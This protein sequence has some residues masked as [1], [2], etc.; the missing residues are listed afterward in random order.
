M[1]KKNKT[2]PIPDQTSATASTHP[3]DKSSDFCIHPSAELHAVVDVMNVSNFAGVQW[4]HIL[5]HPFKDVVYHGLAIVPYKEI[6]SLAFENVK[7]QAWFLQGLQK[8]LRNSL[9]SFLPNSK[10]ANGFSAQFC[11]ALELCCTD[12]QMQNYGNEGNV[13]KDRATQK[14]W[15][16]EPGQMDLRCV[17]RLPVDIANP[18]RA[19]IEISDE[20][21]DARLW[22]TNPFSC[23]SPEHVKE[24]S[25]SAEQILD[26]EELKGAWRREGDHEHLLREY[27]WYK[28]IKGAPSR[29]YEIDYLVGKLFDM[30]WEI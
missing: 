23:R 8:Y 21:L 11:L 24:G 30:P 1:T 18:M 16:Y 13:W 9:K 17:R 2:L 6:Y 10:Y 27:I 29:Q 19:M 26:L 15:V 7:P 12:I 25:D 22:I 14:I 4:E 5:L 3:H 28:M 20:F